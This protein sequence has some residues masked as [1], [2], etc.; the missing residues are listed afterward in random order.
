MT[1]AD[2][3]IGRGIAANWI[4]SIF[5]D[6]YVNGIP[7][8]I[9]ICANPTLYEEEVVE[10]IESRDGI[11]KTNGDK[12]PWLWPDSRMTD[13]AYMF[14]QDLNRVVVSHYGGEM[15]DPIKYMKGEN[16]ESTSLGLGRPVFPLEEARSWTESCPNY[17]KTMDSIQTI[18]TSR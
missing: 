6:G 3:Y 1:K 17:I 10:F 4:G 5:S 15:F 11:I 14:L 9:L 12:W 16:T 2:F 13:Y 7:L 18:V 8:K